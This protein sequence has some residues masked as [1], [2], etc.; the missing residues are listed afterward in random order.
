MPYPATTGCPSPPHLHF[1]NY[2]IIVVSVI[3]GLI[4]LLGSPWTVLPPGA[5]AAR[6]EDVAIA[7]ATNTWRR[8]LFDGLV[9]A[10]GKLRL[11]G[12]PAIYLDGSYVTGKPRPADFD[13][14]WDHAGVDP[15]KLDPVFLEFANGRAAQKAAFKGEFFPSSMLCV[16]VGQAF[17]DFFQRDRF[18]GKQKGIISIPLSADPL[19]SGKVQP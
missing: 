4:P 1:T 6:L 5:H 19:L 2:N 8:E 18:T 16:D 10:S 13:A 9:L 12:C 15:A 17:V 14:C 7:F 11:A 3:P